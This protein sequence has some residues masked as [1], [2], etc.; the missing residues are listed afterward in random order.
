M[1]VAR[2]DSDTFYIM[3]QWTGITV[4]STMYIVGM[5][6]DILY[7]L[8]GLVVSMLSR[9]CVFDHMCLVLQHLIELK[10]VQSRTISK[11]NCNDHV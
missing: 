11:K 5:D 8:C 9:S 6:G 3:E 7:A 4:N 2:T 10:V 1:V